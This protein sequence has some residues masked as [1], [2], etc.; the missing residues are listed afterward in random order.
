MGAFKATSYSVV[1]GSILQST[2]EMFSREG[3]PLKTC[4]MSLDPI[5]TTPHSTGIFD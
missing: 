2:R 5:K 4:R 3:E 1:A